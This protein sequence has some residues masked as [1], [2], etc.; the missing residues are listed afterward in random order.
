VGGFSGNHLIWQQTADT[1]AKFYQT[2]T[3]DNRGAGQSS[4]PDYPYTVEMMAED[5]IGLCQAL[6]L[7]PCH[8]V[9]L[10]MGGCI[11]QTISRRYPEWVKSATLVNTFSQIG[12]GFRLYAEG[13]LAAYKTDLPPEVAL[14]M[15]LGWSFSDAFL[16]DTI[17]L[18]TIMEMGLS[19]P[20]P[21]TEIGYRNQLHALCTIDSTPWLHEIK[22]PSLVIG[23]DADRI[24]TE[25]HMQGLAR[26]IPKAHY[27]SFAGAGHLPP[28][29]QPA[30]FQRV[31]LNFIQSQT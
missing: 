7:T 18:E 13:S 6:Q 8:F 5:T 25:A 11:V 24:V 1:L 20:F 14:K 16:S 21:I 22:V 30:E 28:I 2:I 26:K 3:F 4:V 27:H 17:T 29:E 19:D 31:L 23:S 12:A 9:G 15:G 10:S